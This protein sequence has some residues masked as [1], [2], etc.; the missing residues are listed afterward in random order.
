M[1]EY[2]VAMR[3]DIH[4][5]LVDFL[6]ETRD[7][8][9]ICFALWHPANGKKRNSI[10]ISDIICPKKGDRERHGNVSAMPQYLD[11]VKEIARIK[12]AGL[13]MI[14]THPIG[15]GHQGVSTTDLYYE[16]DILSRE[17]FGYT[18]LPLVG[19]TLSGDE[20]WSARIYP[21]PYEIQWCSG[22]R[23][24]GK[25]LAIHFNPNLLPLP[26]PGKKHI[27]T[28]SVWDDEKHADIMRLKIGIIGLGSIGTGIGQIMSR[29]GI[30]QIHLMD[31]D[32]IK[33]HNLDRLD[34]VFEEDI[35]KQKAKV[36]SQ[37]LKKAAT[38]ERFSCTTST[39][40][41]VEQEGFE[42]ALDCDLL[43]S[44]VDR[45]W[46][47]QIMNHLAYSSLIPVINGGIGFKISKG[48]L[49]HGVYR[50]QTVGPERCCLN[51]HN[52]YDV[53]Q[54][55]QDRDGLLDD[56]E[57]VEEQEKKNGPSRQNIM[58]FVFSLSGLET[59]QFVELVTNL[60][61][62]GDLGEQE[63]NYAT[64]ETKRERHQCVKNCHYQKII[65]LGDTKRPVLGEDKS[66]QREFDESTVMRKTVFQIIS[67][68]LSKCLA[69]FSAS[70]LRLR[71]A[72]YKK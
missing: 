19:M 48:T 62:I 16:Q 32:V 42:E 37:I 2:S 36:V 52:A 8:E 53:S 23:I 15:C 30:G 1:T 5:K 4:K 57:Y 40:S 11:R 35:G 3:E 29:I 69:S 39:Y 41:I 27:T 17:I 9:E 28:A 58:P 18:G 49:V 34:G 55:Q 26:K 6:L 20:T 22:V 24:V 51:C 7:D 59:I 14:H 61:K 67:H 10:L 25:N 33:I 68:N 43:F 70:L 38:N 50:A 12:K 66:K 56:P 47:R 72:L 31:Y 21:R 63:Y 44:C 13:V 45:P 65:G 64:G 54:V 71:S 46:P 60:A